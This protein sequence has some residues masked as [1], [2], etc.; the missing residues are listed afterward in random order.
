MR[1]PRL[2]A[3]DWT[4]VPHR[5]KWTRPF[6]RKTK[7]GFWACAITFQL[8][9]I[10]V[11]SPHGHAV[12]SHCNACILGLIA[13]TESFWILSSHK[14]LK[15]VSTSQEMQFI[16]YKNSRLMLLRK[17][18]SWNNLCTWLSTTPFK[19][20]W[21]LE[22]ELHTFLTSAPDGRVISFTPLQLHPRRKRPPQYR[23]DNC[24]G[25]SE[26]WEGKSCRKS[27]PKSLVVQPAT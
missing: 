25:G 2:P 24:V 13:H 6:R 20:H 26:C 9:S 19:A 7:S 14:H 1:T 17:M 10:T 3:V 11:R 8:A 15:T 22:V 27:N 4:D 21:R 5:F 16:C 12:H 18:T 23:L